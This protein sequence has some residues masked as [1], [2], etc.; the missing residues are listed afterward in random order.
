MSQNKGEIFLRVGKDKNTHVCENVTKKAT[1]AIELQDILK[2]ASLNRET[3]ATGANATSSRSHAVY[4]IHYIKSGGKLLLID[5]AGNE[6]NIETMHHT[7]EQM[8][9]AALI[10]QS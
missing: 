9:Q 2:Q 1:S 4:E 10:N 8:Q 3:D 5:L 6:G 7:K